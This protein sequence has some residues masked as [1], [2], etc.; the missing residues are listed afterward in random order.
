MGHDK[1]H[2]LDR[3]CKKRMPLL[4]Y[5]EVSLGSVVDQDRGVEGQARVH[6]LPQATLDLKSSIM[7]RL[8]FSSCPHI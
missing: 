7:Q 5:A 3:R 2:L 1:A 4:K 8:I 6:P